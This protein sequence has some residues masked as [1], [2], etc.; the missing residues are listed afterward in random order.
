[1]MKTQLCFSVSQPLDK[2]NNFFYINK[3]LLITFK[4]YFVDNFSLSKVLIL[5]IMLYVC[6]GE[7]L[8]DRFVLNTNFTIQIKSHDL[9]P[10]RISPKVSLIGFFVSLNKSKD[11]LEVFFICG[12]QVF[13]TPNII[14]FYQVF[15]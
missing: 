3:T 5:N 14:R 9:Y 15:R 8:I 1:M 4:I 7:N 6:K 10:I 13:S 11:I 12:H 2:Y